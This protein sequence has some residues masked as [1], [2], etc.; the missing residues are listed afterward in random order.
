VCVACDPYPSQPTEGN[1][2][3]DLD[4]LSAVLSALGCRLS[5]AQAGMVRDDL[6]TN[7][8]GTINL[9]EFQVDIFLTY[10][11]YGPY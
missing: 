6:D 7:C 8:D 1:G 10:L 9:E 3:L 4:E 2:E 5:P 11:P